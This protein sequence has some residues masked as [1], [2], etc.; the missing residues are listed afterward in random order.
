MIVII[1]RGRIL[2]LRDGAE[3]DGNAINGSEVTELYRFIVPRISLRVSL[4][5]HSLSMAGVFRLP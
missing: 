5:G 1:N 4:D 2:R 3:A